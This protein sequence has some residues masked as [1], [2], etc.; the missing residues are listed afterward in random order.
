M[1]TDPRAQSR[2][3][4]DGADR[5]AA[6]AYF[7]A[8]GFTDAD[9]AKPLVGVAHCWIE[10]TPCNWNHRTLAMKVKEGIRAAGGTP[11]EFN[12]ITVTDGIA[13]GTEGMKASLV[14]REVIA[15]S[16]ELVARG[17]LLDAFVGISGCDK[18]IPAMVMAMARLNLPSLMLYSG[19]IQYGEHR[20]RK[21]TIQDVFEAIGAHNAGR[22][23]ASELREIENHA[24]P[25]AGAC[26]GQFTAN[27]MATAFEML[28]VSPMGFSLSLIHISEPTR[29]Y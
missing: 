15:D 5:A 27:T 1:T 19:S 14:S 23:D 12:S 25:G 17:H 11:I 3:L 21:I 2:A 9:L 24:C 18:T 26:G 28:G 29:P 7:K 8:V 10:I 20:G 4:V 16:V 6:R 22:I 13:M